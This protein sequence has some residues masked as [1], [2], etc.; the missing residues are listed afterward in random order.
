M[1]I[2][3]FLH[4]IRLIEVST[5]FFEEIDE[6]PYMHSCLNTIKLSLNIFF[7]LRK[8]FKFSLRFFLLFSFDFLFF[9]LISTHNTKK[10]HLMQK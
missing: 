8:K 3:V 2:R 9:G 5:Q 6:K 4:Q 10:A 7:F 1:G